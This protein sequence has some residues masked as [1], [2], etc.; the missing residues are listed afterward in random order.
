MNC[1]KTAQ[2]GASLRRCACYTVSY[3]DEKC[4]AEDR[5][6]HAV[7]CWTGPDSA[8][9]AKK[10]ERAREAMRV[11]QEA[12]KQG[13]ASAPAPFPPDHASLIRK[14]FFETQRARLR[15]RCGVKTPLASQLDPGPEVAIRFS[16]AL[17]DELVVH[18]KEP[19]LIDDG[20]A[21]PP[22]VNQ[23]VPPRIG[24]RPSGSPELQYPVVSV[25]GPDVA[26]SSPIQK[27][28]H[29]GPILGACTTGVYETRRVRDRG[30]GV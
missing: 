29:K 26:K 9:R 8:R 24:L 21:L 18:G 12:G 5:K 3:C 16:E 15:P 27:L 19:Q 4:Q 17:A 23:F 1:G 30:E 11:P 28:E 14:G 13:L 22:D 25:P 2:P 10:K 20:R 6:R 7:F